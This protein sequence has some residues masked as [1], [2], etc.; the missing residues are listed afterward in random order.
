MQR[1][2]LPRRQFVQRSAALLG[3]AATL[4]ALGT[5]S[6]RADDYKALVCIFLYGGNDGMNCVVPSDSA[7]HAAYAEVRG[8]LALPQASLVGLP[9][10]D[11]GLHPA[12]SALR[13]MWDARQLAPVFNVGP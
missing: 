5:D 12:L 6:A 2:T 3:G 7:R 13:P 1:P 8:P 10:S 9:G 11:Y 4:G